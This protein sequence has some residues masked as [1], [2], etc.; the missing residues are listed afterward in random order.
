MENPFVKKDNTSLYVAIAAGAV[1]LSAVAYLYLT[2]SGEETLKSIKHKIKDEAK[3]LAAGV[4]SD[5]TGIHK[6]TLKKVAD[7][8]V[9]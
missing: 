5:K 3:N 7:H 9:K 4:L 8:V 2:E 6:D 1:A